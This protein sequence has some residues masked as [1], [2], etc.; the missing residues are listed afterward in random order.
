M[1]KGKKMIIVRDEQ[2]KQFK[3]TVW[4]YIKEAKAN[5]DVINPH[6]FYLNIKFSFC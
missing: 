6:L 1:E 4:S 5:F 3:P 2:T